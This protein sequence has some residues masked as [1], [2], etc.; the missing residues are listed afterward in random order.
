MELGLLES[1]GTEILRGQKTDEDRTE[2]KESGGGQGR[3][4]TQIRRK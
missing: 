3:G 4:S 1:G 2:R